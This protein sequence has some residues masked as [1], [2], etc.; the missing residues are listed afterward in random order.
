MT[1][2]VFRWHWSKL[3]KQAFPWAVATGLLVAGILA[4]CRATGLAAWLLVLTVAPLYKLIRAIATWLAYTITVEKGKPILYERSGLVRVESRL[5]PVAGI[6]PKSIN[7][8]LLAR[9][10]GLDMADIEIPAM[11]G[12]YRLSG[13]GEAAD[14]WTIIKAHVEEIP[15]KK[16]HILSLVWI[17]LWHQV[18]NLM[19]LAIEGMWV[20][21]SRLVRVV[22]RLRQRE[23]RAHTRLPAVE[24]TQPRPRPATVLQVV[25][26]PAVAAETSTWS[27]SARSAYRTPVDGVGRP[28]LWLVLRDDDEMTDGS[29][30]YQGI[31]FSAQVP[32]LAGRKAF[33]AQFV[34]SD[35]DWSPS[36]YLAPNPKR[37][38][39]DGGI[40][41]EVACQYLDWLRQEFIL[42][43][44]R[45]GNKERLS[46]RIKSI[47]DI[48]R[49]PSEPRPAWARPRSKQA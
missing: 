14:L 42:I 31:P 1:R 39:Y 45:N 8:P 37:L 16:R 9:L 25:P 38:Y 47:A 28:H 6:V 48:E 23:A 5:I 20:A 41:G 27:D 29:N 30:V 46:A 12:P 44:G 19:E 11:G 21:S 49:F 18:H 13:M 3:L 40:S 7:R 22:Y 2:R 34:I 35:G 15:D 17:W 43:P 33:I 32:S 10:F 26:R 4:F 24:D 36:N